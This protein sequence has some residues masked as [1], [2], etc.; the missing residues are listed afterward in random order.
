MAEPDVLII[1]AG[2]IG[3]TLA[4]ELSGRK[5]RVEVIT[6]DAPGAG[7]SATAAG[8]LEV[9]YPLDMPA[10]LRALCAYS[11]DLYPALARALREE[12]GLDVALDTCG[13][14]AVAATAAEREELVRAAGA[15]AGAR[16]LT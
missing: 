11:R 2:V 14:L 13:T 7:A 8:M 6:R 4:R 5:L 12:T 3:L 16:L 15:I 9:H 10:P 1:G